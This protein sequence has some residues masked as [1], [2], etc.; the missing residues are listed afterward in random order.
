M[1]RH[2]L[3][4]KAS[5]S[6]SQKRCRTAV[7]HHVA[8]IFGAAS[9]AVCLAAAPASAQDK[10][11]PGS[12]KAFASNGVEARVSD[13]SGQPVP[14]YASLRY[15]KVNGRAGPSPDYP[16]R[17]N[18]ERAGLPVIVVRESKEW[19]MV[20]DP[21]GDEVWVNQSQLAQ[22]RTAI[23]TDTGSIFREPRTDTGRVARFAAG[24][25]VQLGDCG[26]TWCRIEADGH[27]GWVQ[28]GHLWGADDLPAAP[29]KN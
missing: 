23:T 25:V 15:D 29:G 5:C 16:V 8:Q 27:K 21:M 22:R 13:F 26:N 24:A 28:R 18:Y 7:F 19:R 2:L 14:R 4:T 12:F 1:K 10:L 9:V 17:W 6:V 3:S 11:T 20:R